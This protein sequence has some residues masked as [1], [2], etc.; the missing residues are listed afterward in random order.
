MSS[1]KSKQE[2]IPGERF[3][4]I[5]GPNALQ[6]EMM[7]KI[8]QNDTGI[9]CQ[10][11][12]DIQD[13]SLITGE[14]KFEKLI[15]RDCFGDEPQKII[16]L[17]ESDTYRSLSLKNYLVLFNISPEQG[18]EEHIIQ[19]GAKG[20]FYVTDSYKHIVRGVQAVFKGELW[21]SRE[22]MSKAIMD[23]SKISLKAKELLSAR[24][25]EILSLVAV[26][27]K[28]E[29]ISE[30]LFISPHTVKTH[31]YNIFKKIKVTNRLQAALWAAK[32]L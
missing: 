16:S 12:A 18:I 5:S 20:I 2:A 3:I 27:E 28:N 1:G 30:A 13:I 22:A 25:I 8:L 29:A 11:L 32:N 6:N 17:L 31:I 4:Y 24:E 15:L 14:E 19:L 9:V 10:Y 26:G 23:G 7:A 21:F